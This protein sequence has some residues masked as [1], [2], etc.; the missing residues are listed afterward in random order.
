MHPLLGLFLLLILL[1]AYAVVAVTLIG[2]WFPDGGAWSLL[3][4]AVAGFVW[5]PPAALLLRFIRRRG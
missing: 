3:A 1:L 5:V 2:G 4:F